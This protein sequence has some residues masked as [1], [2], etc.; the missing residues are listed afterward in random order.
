MWLKLSHQGVACQA[1][2]AFAHQVAAS[3]FAIM[4]LAAPLG[5]QKVISPADSVLDGTSGASSTGQSIYGSG[6]QPQ[7]G[8]QPSTLLVVPALAVP[9]L[10]VPG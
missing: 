4:L 7:T 2:C 1:R 5:A 9:A 10:T 6:W 8:P 3:A